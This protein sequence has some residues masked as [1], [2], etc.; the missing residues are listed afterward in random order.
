MISK[1]TLKLA[2]T[3]LLVAAMAAVGVG[4]VFLSIGPVGTVFVVSMFAAGA[5]LPILLPYV[6]AGSLWPFFSEPIANTFA[7]VGFASLPPVDLNMDARDRYELIDRDDDAEP[8][9]Y[10]TRFAGVELGISYDREP[11]AFHGKRLSDENRERIDAYDSDAVAD[12][13][14]EGVGV[15]AIPEHRAGK[16]SWVDLRAASDAIH[17][18][19]PD[20]LEPM[21]NAASIHVPLTQYMEAISGAS[22]DGGGFETLTYGILML[23]FLLVGIGTGLVVF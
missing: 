4:R 12:G 2:G 3:G 8:S 14:S 6:A 17:I 5:M 11:D 19:L 7:R 10:R 9:T 15:F 16:G 20:V 23:L 18:R 1:R 13:G 22:E 21:R